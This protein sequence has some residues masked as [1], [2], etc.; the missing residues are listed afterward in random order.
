MSSQT[1]EEMDQQVR[2]IIMA[3]GGY[4]VGHTTFT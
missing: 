4:E 2:F 1:S 3:W